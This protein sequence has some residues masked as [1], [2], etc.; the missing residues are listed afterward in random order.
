[1]ILNFTSNALSRVRLIILGLLV[2]LGL[3]FAQ[4]AGTTISG[5]VTS[6]EGEALPGVNV[7]IKGTT[8]GTVTNIEGNYTL[9][10]SSGAT[11]LIFSSVG[12]ETKEVNISGQSVIN[13]GLAPDVK[14]LGEVVVVGFGQQSRETLTSSISKLDSKVLESVPFGNAASA[15]QGT[16]SGVRVQQMT[17]QP[18]AAPRVILRGGASINNPNGAEPL[19]IVDG[20][21]RQDLTGI[22]TANIESMQV[23]KD[24][25]ATAIYGARAANGVVIVETKSGTAGKTTVTYNSTFGM[26][27][28]R[29]K[30]PVL[31]ARDM[32]RIHRLGAVADAA[33][34]DGIFNPSDNYQSYAT[35]T[36]WGDE[37][38]GWG[39]ANDLTNETLFTTQYLTSENEHKLNEGWESM[40]D[41]VYPDRTLIFKDTDWQDKLFRNSFTQ[42]HNF[43][44]SGGSENAIVRLNVG[45]M[46]QEGITEMTDYRRFTADLDGRVNLS[47]KI[48]V[49]GG[50][51]YSQEGD[52]TVWS[53][54]NIFERS[55]VT[56]PTTKFQ[57]E[58]GTLAPGTTSSLGNTIY[59]LSRYINDNRRTNL[60]LRGGLDVEILPGL[61]F[62]PT[63]SLFV[64]DIEE[65][66]FHMSYDEGTRGGVNTDRE[67]DGL[68]SNWQQKEFA[69]VLDYQRSFA[70]V[71]G[72]NAVIGANY[73]SRDYSRILAEGRRAATDNVPTLNASGE[74]VNVFSEIREQNI[75]GYF[76]RITYDYDLKY[77]LT[78][79][80]RYDG[81]SNLGA[82]NKW[83]FFPAVSAGWNVH[84]ENFWDAPLQINRLKLRSSYGTSGNLGNLGDYAAQGEYT[85]G[86]AYRGDAAIVYSE[87]ANQE[88]QWEESTTMEIGLDAGLFD[89]KVSLVF[90]YYRRVTDNLITTLSMP[91]ST[92]FTSILTNLG[93]LE[94]KG[95]EFE[96]GF[97]II[98]SNNLTWNIA[99]NSSKNRNE[100]LE[101]PENRNDNNRIG[102][103]FVYDTELGDYT[104]KGGLQEGGRL[105]EMY[106]YQQTGVYST[107]EEADAGPLNEM[108]LLY[109]SE[110]YAGDAAFLDKDGNGVIDPRDRVNVGNEFPEWTGGA[111]T[112]L[113]YKSISLYVRMDYATGHTIMNYVR[114]S[115]NGVY[116]V[117]L[118]STQDLLTAWEKP[119]DQTNIAKFYL[120][121]Q[122]NRGNTW[123]GDSRRNG[124]GNSIYY[125]KGDY[126]SLREVTLS[127]VAP[128]SLY[129]A[130]GFV[131]NLR[132][133]LTA[134]NL[135]YITGYTGL[136]PE[137]G[138][139]DRGRY[140]LPREIILGI[141]ASF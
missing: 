12:F 63:A 8:E 140:P 7:I 129:Q 60:T 68:Y 40:A 113:S 57:Y 49:F 44:V 61:S 87:L 31:N 82:E 106:A 52:N 84:N 22:N 94:N 33:A 35:N 21:Q 78:F 137:F 62:K 65:H 13:V 58:D 85:V 4:D 72:I 73:Y 128:E 141:N 5:K 25:A 138:G 132:I 54:Q 16:V 9:N 88:L 114:T 17:G 66:G 134:N 118:N 70:D 130:I 91:E 46:D 111:S 123:M 50:L 105:G 18:G 43:G 98:K 139:W 81:A 115:T 51:N 119:G 121:D 135:G 42:N 120:K 133:N 107:Q 53:E 47:D 101:L 67:A 19:Y 93:S 124:G 3:T 55:V 96:L 100:I 102:G 24:A 56:D 76:S 23:L 122:Q 95:F 83:G 80:G 131:K 77:L 104:W 59:H 69:G 86:G 127:Y 71:H 92:G 26:G 79:T 136:A 28:L 39:T 1:M 14:A 6:N 37:H 2:P 75:I 90:N 116:A 103:F 38:W 41:P 74:P 89:N 10:V 64:R 112:T 30:F 125:E 36:G 48:S 20:V 110:N 45:I 126:L 97:N 27:Q 29:K 109:G 108:R 117:G 34:K 99:L 32:I 15:L 11:I